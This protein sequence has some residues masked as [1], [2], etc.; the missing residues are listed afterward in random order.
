[1][2]RILFFMVPVLALLA[3]SPA[4]AADGSTGFLVV[5][6]DRGAVGNRETADIVA[7]F[8]KGHRAELL[9][10]GPDAQGIENQY[11]GYIRTAIAKLEAA[12]VDEI[13][14]IPLFVSDADA[15]LSRFRNQ[16]ASYPRK[17]TLR[18]ATAMAGSY[19]AGQILL[20]RVR[21][22]A[23]DPHQERLI[24]LVSGASDA[25]SEKRIRA[26]VEGLLGDL[27]ARLPF[28]EIKVLVQHED[29]GNGT[30]K[31]EIIHTAARRGRTILVP[32]TMDE[33]FSAMMSTEGALRRSYG[34]YDV[35]I[36]PTLLPHPAVVTWLKSVA[37]DYLP[38]TDKRVG[39]IVMPHGSTQPYNDAI[40]RVLTPLAQRFPLEIAYGMADADAISRA[41][42]DL[43]AKGVRRAV[44]VRMY[45]LSEHM[46]AASDYILGLS[47]RIPPRLKR[48]PPRRV[49]TGIRFETFGGY[50][51]DPLI[52]DIWRE[53]ILEISED[54]KRETVILLAHGVRGEAANERRLAVMNR[55][56]D[57]IKEGLDEPFREIKAM[58][59]R[60][61]WPE[62]RRRALQDIR[63]FIEQ[64]S[65]N[66][67]VIVISN[68]LYGSGPYRQYLD[69]L[70]YVL[71]GRGLAPHSNLTRWAEK[72]VEAALAT[73]TQPRPSTAA[74]SR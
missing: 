7:A 32:F 64:R 24:V 20:D 71:D 15:L 8:Q 9:L 5:A 74:A 63:A 13:V 45:G 55:N 67:R 31:R 46:K 25:D 35:D 40:E 19:L 21:E 65:R 29:G 51:E 14:A 58:T 4:S 57:R 53:R 41:V 22:L 26:G 42:K 61:D 23:R 17:A 18:W 30:V 2:S 56:I 6:Q 1:M 16:I 48:N 34:D 28:R 69:G 49:R 60:E 50:E 43:E 52:A 54:P 10:V 12:G 33:K 59:V 38:V 72:G 3:A 62:I 39:I 37:N 66:G 68:R 11:Q 73:L 44:F 70:D 27:R 36:G 47:D